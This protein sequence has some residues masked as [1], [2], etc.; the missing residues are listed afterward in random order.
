MVHRAGPLALAAA[1]LLVAPLAAQ[2]AGPD[3][4]TIAVF[5]DCQTFWGC[6]PDHARR[7]LPYLNWMRNREDADVHVL[8]TSL[9]TGG[10]GQQVTLAFIGLRR[11]PGT[12]DTLRHVSANTDT[13]AEVRDAVTRL[14]K[15]GLTRFLARTA[16]APRLDLTYAAPDS[17]ASAAATATEDPWNFWT[18]R[19]RGGGNLRGERQQSDRSFNGSV[20]AN[21]TTEALKIE[22]SLYARTSRGAF[23]LSDSTEYVNTSRFYSGDAL[24]VWSLGPH[25]AAGAGLS[26]DRTT[27]GN[28]D[29]GLS[30][31]P[32]LEYNIFPYAEST[33]KKLTVTYSLES[34]YFNFEE[35]T[36]T[37]RL[38]ELRFRHELQLGAQIQQPWGQIFGSV[39]GTQYF[40]DLSVHRI[41]TFA[42]FTLRVFRGLE[43]NVFGDFARIKDQFSLPAAGLTNEEILL[44]RRALETDYRYGVNFSLSYRF[45]SK[46]ANVVNPRMGGGNFFI[47]F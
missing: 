7:E 15:L 5:L 6:D 25:W 43:L 10:G 18:F 12:A 35:I 11:F 4:G 34:A 27:F 29:L 32:A 21:R 47:M 41:D 39:S 26:A 16:L 37:G 28:L 19:L 24:L 13:Q 8:V 44:Q 33:R 3:G 30:G 14:L 17:A 2:P 42:G 40:H 45:G 9:Q 36:V 46:Y 31:G 22:L 38:D 23:T 1:L 20:S